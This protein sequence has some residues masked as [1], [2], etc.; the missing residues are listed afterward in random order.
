MFSASMRDTSETEMCRPAGCLLLILKRSLGKGLKRVKKKKKKCKKNYLRAG[1]TALHSDF[2][3][4]NL[5]SLS[6]KEDGEVTDLIKVC[7][8]F[9]REKFVVSKAIFNLV[10]KGIFM[11]GSGILTYSNRNNF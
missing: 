2:L 8:Y 9:H 1:E 5:L 11:T 4:C 6:K 3:Q 10:E 7:K